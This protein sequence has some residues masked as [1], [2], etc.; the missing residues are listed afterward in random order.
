MA[1]SDLVLLFYDGYERCAEPELGPW[2][3]NQARRPARMLWRTLRRQQ[4][5]TGHFLT[6]RSLRR[7]LERAGCTVKV[8]DFA[9]ARRMPEHPIGV[10]GYT[11]A[12]QKVE[13]LPNPR[14]VGPAILNSPLQV[15][16]FVEDPRNRLFIVRSEWEQG[17]FAPFF[18]DMV[19]TWSRGY[20]VSEFVDAKPLPKSVDV[21]IYDKIYHDRQGHYPR[22][23]APFIA[24][25]EAQ[26]LSYLMFRYGAYH[27]EAYTEALKR[28]R[29]MAYFSHTDVQGNAQMQASIMNV[30]IFAW[31]E[32]VWLDPLAK[33]ISNK[34]IACTSVTHFD[35]RCGLRF[36]MATMEALWPQ[37]WGVRER[38]EPRAYIAE[39]LTLE[40]SAA[41]YLRHYR[42]AGNMGAQQRTL[43]SPEQSIAKASSAGG[44]RG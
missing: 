20:D 8:N 7:T 19:R 21:L 5:W 1:A 12:L 35:D 44:A 27:N 24:M 25:L 6:Y 2:L 4:I 14:L 16:G 33:Q 11:S 36:K 10:C 42:E 34:P 38:Y 3:V 22:T 40:G 43:L 9:L 37:F 29:A 30:P 15:P 17:L 23:I 39:A 26:G 32:G 13:S 41:L 28:C 18:G 31:D